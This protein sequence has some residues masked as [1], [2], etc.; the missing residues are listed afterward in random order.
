MAALPGHVKCAVPAGGMVCF[1]MR[2][3]HTGL[4]L[5][6]GQDRENLIFTYGA[7]PPV[8]PVDGDGGG[9]Q[10]GQWPIGAYGGDPTESGYQRNFLECGKELDQMGRLRTA[11]RRQLFGVELTHPDAAAMLAQTR[12]Q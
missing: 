6:N 2:C 3:W 12:R 11:A 7:P 9:L 8:I 5:L 4:P 1:D 10:P